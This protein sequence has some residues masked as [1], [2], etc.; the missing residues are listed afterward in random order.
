MGSASE[1]DPIR[2]RCMKQTSSRWC[3][4]IC[5]E[6]EAQLVAV[7]LAA[8]DDR[9]S[10]Q[11]GGCVAGVGRHLPLPATVTQSTPLADEIDLT[12]QGGL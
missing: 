6:G 2:R 12:K 3:L 9:F 11:G 1:S 4:L 5:S 8:G 7:L 10:R